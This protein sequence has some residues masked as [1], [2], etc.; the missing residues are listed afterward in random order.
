MQGI[1]LSEE[2]LDHQEGYVLAI[3]YAQYARN[4]LIARLR[5]TILSLYVRIVTLTDVVERANRV[6]QGQY[7]LLLGDYVLQLEYDRR[8][9]RAV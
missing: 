6:Y 2:K 3:C 8:R 1:S 9:Y 7:I 4:V 5:I